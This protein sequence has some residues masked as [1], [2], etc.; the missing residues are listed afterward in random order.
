[1]LLCTCVGHGTAQHGGAI[2]I[3]LSTVICII[4]PPESTDLKGQM[5]EKKN[6]PRLALFDQSS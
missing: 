2:Y 1:M 3:N 4:D 6:V 5:D